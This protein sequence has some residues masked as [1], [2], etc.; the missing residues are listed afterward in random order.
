MRG[1]YFLI[2]VLLTSYS[3]AISYLFYQSHKAQQATY[4]NYVYLEYLYLQ[5]YEQ[6]VL[7]ARECEV[8]VK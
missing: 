6:L 7:A 3:I 2:M 1:F 5:T 8:S 4:D